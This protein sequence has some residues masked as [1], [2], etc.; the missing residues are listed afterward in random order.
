MPEVWLILLLSYRLNV[1]LHTSVALLFLKAPLPIEI[2]EKA[3]HKREEHL[4][5]KQRGYRHV[6]GNAAVSGYHNPYIEDL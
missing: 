4:H 1:R 2:K 5:G 3:S 6:K